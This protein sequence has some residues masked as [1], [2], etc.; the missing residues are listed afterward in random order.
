MSAE[1][2]KGQNPDID[3]DIRGNADRNVSDVIGRWM[4]LLFLVVMAAYCDK[5]CRFSFVNMVDRL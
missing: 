1:R 2:S 3:L 4:M 5:M